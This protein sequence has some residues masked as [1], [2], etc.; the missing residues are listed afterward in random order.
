MLKYSR[1]VA[2]ACGCGWVEAAIAAWLASGWLSR[3]WRADPVTEAT[4]AR[5]PARLQSGAAAADG[6][7]TI[8]MPIPPQYTADAEAGHSPV[9]GGTADFHDRCCPPSLRID[10]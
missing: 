1:S 7:P 4:V 3:Y 10:P 2:A 6:V 5:T 8:P 9:C